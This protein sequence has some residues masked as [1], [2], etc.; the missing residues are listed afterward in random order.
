M[1]DP[2]D[3]S[4]LD[5]AERLALA[6]EQAIEAGQRADSLLLDPAAQRLAAQVSEEQPFGLPAVST[7]EHSDLRRGF[8]MTLGGLLALVLGLSISDVRHELIILLVAAFVAIGL[9]PAVRFLVRRGLSR[10][11]AVTVIA[12]LLLLSV[13]GFGAA[14][15]PPIS[16]E[17]TQLYN[18]APRY[19]ADLQDQHN[20]LGRLNLKYHITTRLTDDLK[21]SLSAKTATGLLS[22]GTK[23]VSYTFDAFLTLVLVI[24]FLVD[25]PRIKH[26]GYRLVPL[27][28]RPRFGL[29]ADEV[30]NRVGG[31]VL[32]NVATSVVAAV[33]SY[34]LLLI[35]GVPYALVLSILTGILDLIPLVGSSIAGVLVALV[36]LAAVSPTAAIITVIFHV[37][38]RFFED[39]L[40]NPR[41]L[42][43][44]VDVSPLVTIVA[45]VIGGGL[46]G[47]IGALIAVPTA[48]AIQLII[49]EVVYPN[50][51][52]A[53]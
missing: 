22:A 11:V 23:V 15:F 50:Q 34:V 45:V 4:Y 33:T 51:D 38:Y 37:L 8:T 21:S 17:A 12:L 30:I 44:T 7:H 39:Y 16:R 43:K 1:T 47:I 26:A 42:R 3:R 41:V 19:A 28:N 40:L 25:L 6:A 10:A 32:G 49:T 13:A 2:D 20:A 31:Y 14:A 52:A 9:D 48:A 24:Y 29:L 46:L 18:A 27:R 53:T 35:L 36:A 5:E